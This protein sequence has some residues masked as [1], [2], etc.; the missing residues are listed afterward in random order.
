MWPEKVEIARRSLHLES[1]VISVPL[2]SSIAEDEGCRPPRPRGDY[3]SPE[4]PEPGAGCRRTRGRGGS[5]RGR[6][7]GALLRLLGAPLGLPHSTPATRRLALGAGRTVA[8]QLREASMT[9]PAI[10]STVPSA[11]SRDPDFI[12]PRPFACG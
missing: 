7:S 9:L 5:A 3:G 8:G 11:L 2:G 1:E 10:L 6:R 12:T 4:Q